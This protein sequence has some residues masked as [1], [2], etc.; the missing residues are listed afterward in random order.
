MKV[1]LKFHLNGSVLF[2]TKSPSIPPIGSIAIIT[3][4]SYKKGLV[5]GSLIKVEIGKHDPLEVAYEN[6]G[7]I[8]VHISI[9][10]YEVL[11]EGAPID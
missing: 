9:N 1:E 4:E 6:D 7:T 5:P 10:G 3:T 8:L 2:S 11:K